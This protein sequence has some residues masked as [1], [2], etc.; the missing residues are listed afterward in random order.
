[1]KFL[2]FLKIGIYDFLRMNNEIIKINLKNAKWMK[3]RTLMNFYKF[4]N[5]MNIFEHKCGFNE[6]QNF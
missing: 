3:Y 1:M 4:Y 5:R 2:F 6:F